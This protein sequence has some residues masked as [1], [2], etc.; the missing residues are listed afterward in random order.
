[1]RIAL[2]CLGRAGGGAAAEPAPAA[3]TRGQ[4]ASGRPG[5]NVSA[6]RRICRFSACDTGRWVA[7]A[8]R[9]SMRRT[10][11]STPLERKVPLEVRTL[12]STP[13]PFCA[14]TM[15]RC[16]EGSASCGAGGGG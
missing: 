6:H 4:P 5:S 3:V 16:S 13:L 8:M 14:T 1:M 12:S 15:L 2:R 7:S 10:T 9:S 11:S